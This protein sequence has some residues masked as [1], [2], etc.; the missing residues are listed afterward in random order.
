MV[1][2][3][4]YLGGTSWAES[5]PPSKEVQRI[6]LPTAPRAARAGAVDMSALPKGPPY[7]AFLGNL[8]YDIEEDDIFRFFHNVQVANISS[9]NCF[10][11]ALTSFQNNLIPRYFNTGHF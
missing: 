9:H 8:P 11:K 10:S 6:V 4:V 5:Y 1:I 7:T 3:F 2:Y